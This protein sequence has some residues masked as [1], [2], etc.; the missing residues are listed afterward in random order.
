MKLEAD[1]HTHTVASGHGYSTLK[2]MV[3]A[4][5]EKGL[6]MLGITDHGLLMPGGPHFYHFTNMINWPQTINGVEVLKGVE[7]NIINTYG[8]IDVPSEVLEHLDLVLAGF[9]DGTGYNGNSV[10]DNTRA[11]VAAIKNPCV[12]IIVH[13]GNPKYPVDIEKVVLAAR[14]FGKALELNNNS[15][16]VRPGSDTRCHL[17][18]KLCKKYK[19]MVALN[20]D[21][22][23]WCGVGECEKAVEL[24]TEVGISEE[25]ILNTSA[26]RVR[27]FITRHKKRLQQYTR[28]AQN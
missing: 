1:L 4:A 23:L 26:E 12:H 7:G 13:P 18:A 17:L 11:M 9:H 27:D 3:E 25:Y 22:H 2:E 16:F 19:V 5:S 10:E 24:A 14:V 28:K 21:A 20:S 15:F 8:Q 6:K